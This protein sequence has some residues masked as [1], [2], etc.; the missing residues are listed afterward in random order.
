MARMLVGPVVACVVG[1]CAVCA[2]PSEVAA[3]RPPPADWLQPEEAPPDT[4]STSAEDLPPEG[5]PQLPREEP[6][7]PSFP[8]G[9]L[10]GLGNF[11]PSFYQ[12]VDESDSAFHG[13]PAV[14]PVRDRRGRVLARVSRQYYARLRMEGSGRLRDGRVLSYH[15]RL[16]GE[17]RFRFTRAQYGLSRR[18]LPLVPFRSVAVDPRLIPLGSVLYVPEAAG[19]PLEDGSLHD[20]VFVADD[21]GSA[22]RGRRLDFFVGFEDHIRNR[23]SR[24][25][26][27]VHGSPVQVY[28]IPR[29]FADEIAE[30]YHP[31]SA[32]QSR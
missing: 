17:A 32:R 13:R 10:R 22:V 23:F 18:G 8:P 21:V 14:R 30:R 27:L 26:K 20:G 5:T 25:G 31:A 2:S 7:R 4:H 9:L 6:S 11:H 15:A 19:T 1:A 12:T 3:P 28:L 24:S 29:E 16:R